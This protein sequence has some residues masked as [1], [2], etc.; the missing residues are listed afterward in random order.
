MQIYNTATRRKEEL[1]THEPGKVAMYACGP[2]V[3]NYIHI[4]NAR[5][6]LI[7]DM[8]RKYLKYRGYEVAFVQNITDVDDK[9][10]KR[11]Q[12]EGKTPEEIPR[13]SSTTCTP[14]ASTIR[15]CAHVPR[16]RFPR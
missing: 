2:T 13:P 4:G 15:T 6:F 10:I 9:I 16:R 11:A 1:V 3:Y 14:S 5:T 7:F 12:E 8:V